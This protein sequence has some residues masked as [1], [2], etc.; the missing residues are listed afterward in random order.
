M[1]PLERA[2]G[3]AQG[4]RQELDRMKRHVVYL[5]IPP[6][7]KRHV[8]SEGLAPRWSRDPEDGLAAG[9]GVFQARRGGAGVPGLGMCSGSTRARS[10]TSHPW[11]LRP[12]ALLP[13]RP[14]AHHRHPLT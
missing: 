6:S 13:V 9:S 2:G 10:R 5:A 7:S 12:S 4:G 8:I 3:A 14:L 11:H 1:P